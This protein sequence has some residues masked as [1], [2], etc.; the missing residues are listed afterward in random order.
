VA[1]IS[2]AVYSTGYVTGLMSHACGQMT[3]E[4][5]L[6][7]NYMHYI[8]IACSRSTIRSRFIVK[9]SIPYKLRGAILHLHSSCDTCHMQCS[10]Q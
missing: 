5:Y 8:L 6:R 9:T 7:E 2:V 4:K 3:G 10:I 1:L